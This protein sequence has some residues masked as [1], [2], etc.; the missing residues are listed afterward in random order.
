MSLFP[1][2][3]LGKFLKSKLNVILTQNNLAFNDNKPTK[4]TS[5]EIYYFNFSEYF[6]LSTLAMLI[7]LSFCINFSAQNKKFSLLF[8]PSKK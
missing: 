5:N 8:L 7:F 2:C 1:T 6:C 4:Y 3:K